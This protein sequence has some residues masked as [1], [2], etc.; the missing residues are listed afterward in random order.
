MLEYD[1]IL[2]GVTGFTGKLALEYLLEKNYPGLRFGCCARNEAKAQQVVDAVC[3]QLAGR[4][5]KPV[6]AVKAL[7]PAK[8]EIADLVCSS[9]AEEEALRCIVKKAKV[10]ITTAGPFEKYGQTLVKLCAEEGV[11]YADIT[12]ESDFFRL[13]IDLHDETA[14]KS[15][16]AIVIHCGNDCIPWDLSVF[17]L[18]RYAQTKGAELISAST[19]CDY[20]PGTGMSG[21]TLTT[22]IYQL[23]KR[24]GKRSGTTDFDPLV[25]AADGTKS[26][27]SLIN[28]SPKKEEYFR[29]FQR[30]GGPWIMA[31]VMVN[32]IRRSNALLGYSSAFAY[33]DCMLRDPS[34]LQWIRDKWQATT[35]AAAILAPSLFLRFMP[36]PGEGPTREFMDSGW[37]V[38]H[39]RAVMKDKVSQKETT[40]H[41]KYTF[42]EDVSYLATAKFL[43]EA[44]RLLLE[45]SAAGEGDAGVTTPAVAF[46]SQMVERLDQATGAQLEITEAFEVTARSAL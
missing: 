2:F 32:C 1:I 37:L 28:S 6:E 40:L 22:A 38:L 7:A 4:T 35:T 3:Q 23:N 43:V 25:R 45:K 17:E 30:P 36:A 33:G 20:K 12:G 18:N 11:H 13:V 19:Y 46:G 42:H 34:L 21:G 29:E 24:R 27:F 26:M 10:C 5:G 14:R 41:A 31:P 39:S 8:I 9:P 44:G 15:G 16:A